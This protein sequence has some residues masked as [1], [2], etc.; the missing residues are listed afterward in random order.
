MPL[1][2]VFIGYDPRQPLAYNV[3]HYSI[4]SR[5]SE[6]A[7]VTPLR[8][9]QLPMTRAGLTEFTYSRFLVPWICDYQGWALFMDCDVIVLGDIAELFA[10]AD[11]RYDVMVVKN[12]RVFEWPSVMLFNCEKCTKLTPEF[13]EDPNV[14]PLKLKTW[15]EEARIGALPAEWNHL[16]GYDPER[17][18]AKLVHY[19]QGIPYWPEVE[20]CE[21]E[22]DW[23]RMYREM[24][25]IATWS[26]IMGKSVHAAPN[27]RTQTAKLQLPDKGAHLEMARK[28]EQA[29]R[30]LTPPVFDPALTRENPSPRFHELTEQYEQMHREGFEGKNLAPE[31]T[32]AGASLS[33][34][35]SRVGKMISTLDAKTV[36]DYGSGKGILYRT[37]IDAK[38]EADRPHPKPREIWGIDEITCYDPGVPE[39][40]EFPS[41]TFDGVICSDVLEH[42]PEE[43]IGW[44]VDGL[45]ALADKFVFA[46]A[47]CYAAEKTLPNGENCHVTLK[48][49][50]WWLKVFLTVAKNHPGIAWQLGVGFTEDGKRPVHIDQH[51]QVFFAG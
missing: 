18:D 16:V 4:V 49:P 6:P 46:F 17:P 11:D 37:D 44:F 21:Y 19:T 3:C 9:D 28:I 32:F 22:T 48:P 36:L 2:R 24:N 33:G 45:F 34:H 1:H 38:A 27:G 41:G 29:A 12:E 50:E 51:K 13:V 5:S 14:H 7:M 43:D 8:L 26:E 40:S 39:F 47:S 25:R 15:T 23:F 30:A 31:Q 10:L 35:V 42:V 20:G